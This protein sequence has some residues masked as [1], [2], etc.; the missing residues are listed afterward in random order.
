MDLARHRAYK[1][2]P[3]QTRLLT[4]E[5][6]VRL[7]FSIM[8]TKISSLFLPAGSFATTD[9]VI[10]VPGILFVPCCTCQS[11][12]ALVMRYACADRSKIDLSPI[13]WAMENT[14]NIAAGPIGGKR[15]PS[16]TI[17]SLNM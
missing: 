11:G 17:G 9:F 14:I 1:L 16:T 8:S 7:I 2:S 6:N 15:P 10:A 12:R 3:E 5:L 4:L 13:T